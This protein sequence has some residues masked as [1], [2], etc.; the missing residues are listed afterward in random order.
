MQLKKIIEA[1][2]FVSNHTLTTKQLQNL[3]PKL[4]PPSLKEIDSVCQSLK[5]DYENHAIELKTLA[6]GYRFQVRAEFSPWI[7]RLFE[8]KPPKY[9]KAL[10]ETLSV[11]VYHQPVTRAEIEEIRGVSISSQIMM[12]LLEREWINK[13]GH[14]EIPGRPALYATSQQFL[15]YFNV[16]SLTQLPVLEQLKQWDEAMIQ[17]K[18]P[19]KGS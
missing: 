3:F 13:T 11:I 4:P 1:L 9:S 18:I 12:T 5:R 16:S 15:D 7:T 10:L 8:E 14:K 6:T 17:S 19:L 2:L